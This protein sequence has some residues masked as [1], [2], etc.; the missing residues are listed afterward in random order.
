MVN[1]LQ[2]RGMTPDEY[3]HK[4]TDYDNDEKPLNFLSV[5]FLAMKQKIFENKIF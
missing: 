2:N 4:L 1:G 5:S 3:M